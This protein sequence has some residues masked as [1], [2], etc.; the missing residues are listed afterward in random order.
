MSLLEYA[1]ANDLN[2]HSARRSMS[3]AVAAAL[4]ERQPDDQGVK[5][6]G[7]APSD[8]AIKVGK[9]VRQQA[10]QMT[11]ESR[12]GK[13][14]KRGGS[15]S[16]QVAESDQISASDQVRL[17]DHSASDQLSQKAK[18]KPKT[19]EKP[20]ESPKKG[21]SGDGSGGGARKSGSGRAADQNFQEHCPTRPNNGAVGPRYGDF[22]GA[23][24]MDFG[25]YCSLLELDDEIRDLAVATSHGNRDLLLA[26]GRYMTMYR[27]QNQILKR[28]ADNYQGGGAW[29]DDEGNKMP[30]DQAEAQAIFGIS[31]R[32]TELE[33][34]IARHKLGILKLEL[35]REKM[36]LEQRKQSLAEWNRHPLCRAERI[37]RT[38][39]LLD[40][41]E[42]KGLSAIET[43]TMFNREDIELPAALHAEMIKEITWLEPKSEQGSGITMEELERES[44][45]YQEKQ[46]KIREEW[47]PAR[48]GDIAAIIAEEAAH[49]AGELLGEQAFQN[50]ND[51]ELILAGDD[52][53]WN[54]DDALPP[55]DDEPAREE[56]DEET[57]ETQ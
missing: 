4:A 43:A 47:L 2:R 29:I 8:A 7:Q 1:L 33:S 18:D 40:L 16:D 34:S 44:R 46:R 55:D 49:Q 30:Q 11:A 13:G 37:A 17:S 35:D 51:G 26:Q 39:E 20:R 21:R 50:G 22:G 56:W 36:A 6:A 42:E 38:A 48:N 32:M 12:R 19:Q 10:R 52:G 31:Q 54:P 15:T 28:I 53:A 9:V 14:S 27:K 25:G 57:W 45:E 5:P 24:T 41:R 23:H 3:A